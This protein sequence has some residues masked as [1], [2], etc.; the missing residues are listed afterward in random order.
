MSAETRERTVTRAIIVTD[1]GVLLGKRHH[2]MGAKQFALIGGKPEGNETPEE[3]V[4][5]EVGEETGLKLKNPV[6]FKR[7]H[8]SQ[9]V[10]GE[11]WDVYYFIGKGEGELCL[12]KDEVLEAKYVDRRTFEDLDIAF[13]HREILEEFFGLR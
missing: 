5:R 3:C 6:L 9:S 2:G 12:K 7:I 13:D 4:T 10:P 1:E 8:D 11:N